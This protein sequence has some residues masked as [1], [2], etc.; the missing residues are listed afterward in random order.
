MEIND[1]KFNDKGLVVAIASDA[2]TNEV[3]MQAYMNKEALQ[4]TLSTGKAHYFS[5]SRNKLWLKGETSGHFQEVVS[6]VSDCDNDCIL[7]RVIQTGVACHTGSRT[8]FINNYTEFKEMPN[9]NILQKNIDTIS[10]RKNCPV[11]GSYTNYLL[12]KGVEK[13][14]KKVGEEASETIIAA[15]KNDKEE[16]ACELAD[17]YYHTFVLLKSA[18]M[19]F[20][21]VLKILEGRHSKERKRNY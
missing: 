2:F 4:L 20:N 8:C 14:C 21:D 13:I 18:G 1:I 6:I 19:D 7:M 16:L 12:D 9:I 11:E 3:L 17:L 15:M 10:E 5:R